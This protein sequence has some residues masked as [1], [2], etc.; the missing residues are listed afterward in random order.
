MNQTLVVA[1]SGDEE[2][3]DAF[4]GRPRRCQATA[5]CA[6]WLHLDETERTAMELSSPVLGCSGFN[7]K[8]TLDSPVQ[9]IVMI[10][11]V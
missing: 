2:E 10:R 7:G 6:L 8:A 4:N 1:R 5:G 9:L 3:G 11:S